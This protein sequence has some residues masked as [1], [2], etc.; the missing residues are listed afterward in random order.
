MVIKECKRC[1]PVQIGM[2]AGR[3]GHTI[4]LL[5]ARKHKNI[6][7][8]YRLTVFGNKIGFQ[9]YFLLSSFIA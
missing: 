3:S 1:P 2:S 4:T 7:R 8:K 9:Y 5:Q 6:K